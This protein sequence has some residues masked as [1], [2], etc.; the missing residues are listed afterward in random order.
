MGICDV[1]AGVLAVIGVYGVFAYTVA[2]RTQEIGIRMALG[3]R[4]FQVMRQIM[5][6]SL[7]LV[8]AGITAGLVSAAF[9]ARYLESLLFGVTR[10]D[11]ATFAAVAIVFAIVALLASAIPAQRAATV[12]PLIALRYQ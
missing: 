5:G 10:S 1:V 3:A 9:L 12:D 6:Q 11:T 2:R 4:G 7:V 8:A